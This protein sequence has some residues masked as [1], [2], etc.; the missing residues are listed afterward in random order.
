MKGEEKMSVKKE[1]VVITG[2]SAGIGRSTAEAFAKRKKNLILVARRKAKLEELKSN[3]LREH[4]EIDVIV[5]VY[6][7]S[8]P[9]NVYNF[10]N[11]LKLD[12]LCIETWINNA[13]MGKFGHFIDL[14][15]E[16][17]QETVHLNI[18]ATTIFSALFA[19]DHFNVPGSQLINVSSAG[20]YLILPEQIVY[21]ASKFYICAF[22][23]GLM[24]E[25]RMANAAMKVKLFAPSATKTE[26]DGLAIDN[27]DHVYEKGRD[28]FQTSEEVAELLFQLYESDAQ[29]GRVTRGTFEYN[30]LEPQFP[31]AIHMK[32]V[33]SNA[34]SEE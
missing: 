15:V 22:T 18:E 26:F 16:K 11:G 7:L 27:P 31:F 24:H 32:A 21:C 20:G 33:S 5:K 23:E 19:K 3:L 2:A 28:K 29:V 25:V 30:L 9:Q 13:G 17:Q 1:Y 14:D 6:D 12:G 8:I 10:Y 4:P 34:F